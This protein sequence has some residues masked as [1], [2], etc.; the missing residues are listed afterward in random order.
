MSIF[1][2]KLKLTK[3]TKLAGVGRL[4]S[5]GR[6]GGLL[7]GCIFFD[8]QVHVDGPI[9]RGAYKQQLIVY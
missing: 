6:G 3:E 8:L 5:G 4:R 7:I 1:G 2:T 9:T